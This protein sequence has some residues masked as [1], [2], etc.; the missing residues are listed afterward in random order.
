MFQR[1]ASFDVEHAAVYHLVEV[2][3]EICW[4]SM[5]QSLRCA[6]KAAQTEKGV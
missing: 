4:Q 1:N 3:A 2:L 6:N 5:V